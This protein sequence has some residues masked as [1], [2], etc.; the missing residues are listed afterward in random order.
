MNKVLVSLLLT[1]GLTGVAQA[2][3]DAEAGQG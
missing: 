2:A 1:L 3:G